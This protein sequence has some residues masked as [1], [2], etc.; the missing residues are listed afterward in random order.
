MV[1]MSVKLN[2]KI[3]KTVILCIAI[4][5]IIIAFF[6]SMSSLSDAAFGEH[7][8]P[9]VVDTVQSANSNV[10]DLKSKVESNAD[11]IAYCNLLGLNVTQEPNE[12]MEVRI[13]DEFD[14]VYQNYNEMQKKNGFD[15][16][17][18]KGKNVKRWNYTVCNYPDHEEG[19]VEI[20]LLVY[21]NKVIGGDICSVKIDGFMTGLKGIA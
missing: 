12:V 18:Y 10:K 19:T 15:L 9:Q 11:R 16:S 3:L 6:I 7:S 1:I 14:D 20:N 8:T 2:K 17:K 5:I 21:K 13:P 4:A